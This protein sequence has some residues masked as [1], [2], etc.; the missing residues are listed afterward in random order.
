MFEY[1]PEGIVTG[2]DNHWLMLFGLFLSWCSNSISEDHFPLQT[3]VYRDP[4]KEEDS[5]QSI[6]TEISAAAKKTQLS[7]KTI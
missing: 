1:P 2:M 7:E 3:Y 5:E 4:L 6:V